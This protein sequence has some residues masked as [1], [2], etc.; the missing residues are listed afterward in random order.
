MRNF[1]IQ[2]GIRQLVY[3][4]L[5]DGKQEL[6]LRRGSPQCVINEFLELPYDLQQAILSQLEFHH[7]FVVLLFH[8]FYSEVSLRHDTIQ[9]FYL[10]CVVLLDRDLL[11]TAF[12]PLH[13]QH[14]HHVCD[15]FA[16]QVMTELIQ[17]FFVPT[18]FHAELEILLNLLL[19]EDI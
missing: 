12:A 8:L 6:G 18:P 2:H 16:L 10:L 4:H 7:L 11:I 17:T 19:P 15:I 5:L 3:H 1:S 9:M 13:A 14:V